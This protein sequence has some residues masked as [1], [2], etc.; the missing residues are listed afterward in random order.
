MNVQTYIYLAEKYYKLNHTYTGYVIL[1]FMN[2][3]IHIYYTQVK[4]HIS[5]TAGLNSIWESVIFIYFMDW[6]PC[7][8]CTYFVVW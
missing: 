2:L 1:Q 4:V 6:G 8:S 3:A 7:L 5:I